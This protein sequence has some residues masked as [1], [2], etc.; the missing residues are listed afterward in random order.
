M[1]TTATCH[2]GGKVFTQSFEMT[3]F[4]SI[5]CSTLD[6]CDNQEAF[7]PKIS[8]LNLPCYEKSPFIPVLHL[9]N[10]ENK[11]HFAIVHTHCNINQYSHLTS[12]LVFLYSRCTKS[13]KPPSKAV[14][15]TVIINLAT[16]LSTSLQSAVSITA[17]SLP[18][19]P[20]AAEQNHSAV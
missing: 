10:T 2:T 14:F 18:G 12:S 8:D 3:D 20:Q 6:E 13:L 4:N 16:F 17:P 19:D 7:I 5:L 1:L 15:S 9:A 11:C